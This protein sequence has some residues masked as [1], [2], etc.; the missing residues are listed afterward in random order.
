MDTVYLDYAATTPIDPAVLNRMY[1][2]E[3]N[4]YGNPSSMHRFG[5]K[6]KH[7]LEEA[8]RTIAAAVGVQPNEIVFTSGGT[9]SDNMAVIGTAAA[10]R[11][12]GR[13][14]I[15]TAV[16]HPAVL[17]SCRYLERAG[18]G[19]TYL[20]VDRDGR[21][22]TERL[23]RSITDE[24]ILV[25]IMMANNETGV[26]FPLDEIAD[27]IGKRDIVLHC[28][29]VQAFG[30]MNIDLAEKGVDLLSLSA[31]KIYGPK[32]IGALYIRR[33]SVVE[34]Y[35]H[36]GSQEGGKRAGTENVAAIGGFAEAV[37][38]LAIQRSE[39]KRIRGLRDRLESG[40]KEAIP[41]MH[42]NGGAV[43]RL[44]GHSNLYFPEIPAD[45]LLM[46]L[47]LKGIAIST[48]SA[49]SS[50]STRPSHVLTAMGFPPEHVA[51]SVRITLGRFTRET[52]IEHTIRTIREIAGR[53][54]SR[55]KHAS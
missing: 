23:Q 15:T 12:K 33:G 41:G 55:V 39:L 46:N 16:E 30:K 27:I 37:E 11:G 18:Y 19:V 48:G 10:R 42:V 1:D 17:E 32:G 50:G 26:I 7:V 54:N 43:P 38:Q 47:D 21:I 25:S 35:L 13:H 20:E 49:C 5:Q 29:A 34:K 2:L 28:D 52:E 24:T 45:S 9:E 44:I 40:L 4:Y 3:K 51:G 53:F 31:H 8:R 14:I 6:S 22:S 36:G